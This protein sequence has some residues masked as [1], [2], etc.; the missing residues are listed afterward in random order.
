MTERN[1]PVLVALDE[2]GWLATI[3]LNRPEARNALSRQLAADLDAA[4][5]GLRE[6]N[7]RRPSLMATLDKAGLR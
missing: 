4:L 5:T 1:A 6:R 7:R 3:T 2:D